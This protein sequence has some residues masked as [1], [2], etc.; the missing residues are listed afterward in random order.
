MAENNDFCPIQNISKEK[1]IDK[2]TVQRTIYY[3]YDKQ[4]NLLSDGSNAYSYDGFS[5]LNRAA[6]PIF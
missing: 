5:R 4:G 6:L 2:Q 1:Y 3:S